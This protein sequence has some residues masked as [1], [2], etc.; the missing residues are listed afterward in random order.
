[1]SKILIYGGHTGWIGQKLFAYLSADPAAF[2]YP[3]GTTVVKGDARLEDRGALESEI[4]K[5]RR[6]GT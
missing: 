1:M 2:G 4:E 5:V 3:A 6:G